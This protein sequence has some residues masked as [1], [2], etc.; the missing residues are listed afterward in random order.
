MVL[1][2]YL[3]APEGGGLQNNV[4]PWLIPEDAFASLEDAYVWRGRVRKRFGYSLL[5]NSQL[6]SRLRIDIGDTDGNGDI[7]VTVPGATFKVGQMFSIGTEIFT[8]NATGTPATLLDTGS[9]TLATYN[10]STGALV[11][12]GADPTT[13]CYFYPA[14]PVMGLRLREQTT[15]NFE[16][17]IA[18]DTQFAYSRSGSG[19][20][21]VSANPIT[22][23]ALFTSSDSQFV[24]TVNYRGTSP[25][26]TAFYATNFVAYDGTSNG[27]QTLPQGSSTWTVLRP[28]LNSGASR[29][30]EGCKVLIGF[31]D[32]LVA[33]NTLEGDY[34]GAGVTSF[35][36]RCRWSASGN[37]FATSAW[38][39]DTVGQGGYIDPPTK[40]AILTAQLLK[41]RLI[42]YFE[43]STW[44]LVYTAD[45]QLPFR[46]QQI[47]SELGAESTFSVVGFDEVALGV[48]NVGIHQCN[49]VSVSRIDQKIPDEV[50]KIHNGNDGVE[51]VYGIRDYYRELVYW[52]FPDYTEDPTFP[53][54]ILVYNYRAQVWAIFHDSFTCF[55]YLQYQNDLTWAEL[56][57]KF[58]TWENWNDPWGSGST[59]SQFP[60]ILAGNQQGWTVQIDSD[61]SSNSQSLYITDMVANTLT[62][63]DHNLSV[64]D[65]VLLEDAEG[66]T[67]LNDYIMEVVTVTDANT[68]VVKL[69]Y[70]VTAPGTYTGNGKLTRVSNMNIT[71][72]QWNPGSPVGQQFR[73]PYIDLLL[74][75]TD[76]GEVSLNYFIDFDDSDPVQSAQTSDIIL[77]NSVITTQPENSLGDPASGSRLWHRVFVSQQGQTVQIKL[78][79]SDEQI[80]DYDIATSNF[81]LNATLLYVEPSGRITG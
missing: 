63:I 12:T 77:G 45:T 66:V 38:E 34:S 22:D 69:P 21:R 9:A 37:P 13:T 61:K 78:F 75:R 60:W 30:L 32:R 18:F 4:E 16:A 35:T 14:E 7:S 29:F 36:N 28:Q 2:S 67:G 24:W 49:G 62:V 65:Y 3:I 39:D 76:L 19:W 57:I 23:S 25:D 47:N 80:R 40:E 33:L 59:Q 55:G 72:K 53:T 5:G 8:V 81:Q 74:D 43:R 50:F 27:I 58:G 41:D 64:G 70:G 42:V 79:L 31:K 6:D 46:W 73:I 52:T 15:Y 68:I 26:L 54:Q 17:T 48:G 1:K 56:G 71:S 11:I 51:R 20:D 10:T 44:E